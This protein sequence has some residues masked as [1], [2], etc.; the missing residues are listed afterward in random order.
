MKKSDRVIDIPR[1]LW[2]THSFSHAEAWGSASRGLVPERGQ[3]EGDAGKPSG[4]DTS[5]FPRLVLGWIDADF[6][7][8]IRINFC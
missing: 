4:H 8:H 7:V 5:L 3:E 2:W 1:V 6:R